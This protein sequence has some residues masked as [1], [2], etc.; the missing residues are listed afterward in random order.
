M[1]IDDLL[2]LG[3]DVRSNTRTLG[4][5]VTPGVS[6]LTGE[7][8]FDLPE[9]DIY[10]G[11]GVH[12]EPGVSRRKVGPVNEL[13]AFMLSEILT[14]RPIE[15][16]TQTVVLV[17]G[18]GGTTIMELLTVYGEV[19]KQL[20]VLGI[21]N[22]SPMVGSYST[23]QEMGGFSIS[24]LTPTAD[25]LNFWRAPQAT[26]YFPVITAAGSAPDSATS[27]SGT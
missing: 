21:S 23:T 1:A 27:E 13:V 3:E 20:A 10:I 24:L 4:A 2:A 18:S 15:P 9:D 16:G 11:M 25:M 6:P 12:G 14:D 26:P 19:S 7:L 5:A 8:M 17:N 22:V